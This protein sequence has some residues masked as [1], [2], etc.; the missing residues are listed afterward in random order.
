MSDN[1]L[2]VYPIEGDGYGDPIEYAAG[3]RYRMEPHY[4]GA[5]GDVNHDLVLFTK[6]REH[7]E[8]EVARHK[9]NE[10]LVVHAGEPTPPAVTAW[11][12]R[13]AETTSKKPAGKTAK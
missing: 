1:G 13:K 3:T 12:D 2:T 10:V 7:E 5:A 11:F 6:D 4:P 8:D 9:A